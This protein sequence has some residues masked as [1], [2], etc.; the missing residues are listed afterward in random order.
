MKNWKKK[1]YEKDNI[2]RG[3]TDAAARRDETGW[4]IAFSNQYDKLLKS[5]N[6]F[7]PLEKQN[8]TESK[9][10]G[11]FRLETVQYQ[12]PGQMRWD[13]SNKQNYRPNVVANHYEENYNPQ[14]QHKRVP[15]NSWY[16]EVVRYGKE[17]FWKFRKERN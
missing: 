12:N 15:G 6:R 3:L 14:W 10:R 7:F 8:D 4:Q 2:I 16:R 11:D 5:V 9:V 1:N 13:T 17:T